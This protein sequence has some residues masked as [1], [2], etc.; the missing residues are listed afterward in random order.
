MACGMGFVQ[1]INHQ[2]PWQHVDC[3]SKIILFVCSEYVKLNTNSVADGVLNGGVG[4]IGWRDGS[5]EPGGNVKFSLFFDIL[6]I[7]L[8][9]ELLK[10]VGCPEK[11][12]L[13][14]NEQCGFAVNCNN[15]LIFITI[16]QK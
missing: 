12:T 8:G 9:V 15:D 7:L 14:N 5:T 2:L 11:K 1:I 10:L 6:F 13:S 4:T 16:K 3:P